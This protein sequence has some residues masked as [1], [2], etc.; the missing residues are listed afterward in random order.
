MVL[1]KLGILGGGQLG[2][3]LIQASI[4]LSIEVNCLDPDANAPCKYLANSFTEGSLKDY[5]TVMHFGADKDIISIEIE[6][7]NVD[8]LEDLEKMGK[9]VFPQPQL[10]RMIQDKR[11]QK[12][13][14]RENNFPTADF[15]LVDSLDE[16]R[17]NTDFLPAFNKIGK[18]GYDGR[19]VVRISNENEIEK[20]FDAPGLLEKAVDFEKELAVIVARNEKGEVRAFPTVEMVFHPTQNL[21]E[22]L[23]SPAQ[24]NTSIEETAQNLAKGIIS[25]LGLVG[26]LAV[27]MFLTKD[28]KVLVNEIAPR[29]HNSGHQTIRGNYTSQ[30]EQHL[31]AI[32]NLPLGDTDSRSFSAMLNILGEDGYEGEAIVEGLEEALAI[33]GV[34][35]FFYGKKMTKPF[36]KMGHITILGDS[37]EQV[38]AKAERV[39]NLIKIKS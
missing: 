1:P 8:A 13:F 26:V 2:K 24:V 27:E 29:P 16:I 25:K 6:H 14:Y 19:G 7:V 11:L 20:G 9:K 12:E 18:G 28:G 4:D 32:F 39:K 3:M 15:I 35:P 38:V 30:Y 33:D 5:D 10:L 22:F 36:R 34:Y 21:V 17:K 23:V 31:R 37:H